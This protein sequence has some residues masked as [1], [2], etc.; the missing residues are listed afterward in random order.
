MADEC[1]LYFTEARPPLPQMLPG[2]VVDAA[3]ADA[4][5]PLIDRQDGP[6]RYFRHGTRSRS[7]IPAAPLPGDDPACASVAFTCDAADDVP[8]AVSCATRTVPQVL[9]VWQTPVRVMWSPVGPHALNKLL[10]REPVGARRRGGG[11]LLMSGL[12]HAHVDV[13]VEAL[14]YLF[15]GTARLAMSRMQE[16][17]VDEDAFLRCIAERAGTG[18]VVARRSAC[19]DGRAAGV[20]CSCGTL[21]RAGSAAEGPQFLVACWALDFGACL[22]S[23]RAR[24]EDG[25]ME[26]VRGCR[27]PGLL[28]AD[29]VAALD[30]AG[31]GTAGSNAA[32]QWCLPHC[33]PAQA[34]LAAWF[35]HTV[36]SS[37]PFDRNGAL[38][39]RL[40]RSVSERW[41]RNGVCLDE[42]T[43]SLLRR[44]DAAARDATSACVSVMTQVPDWTSGAVQHG[45]HVSA[46][47]VHC[48]DLVPLMAARVEAYCA[49]SARSHRRMP[50]ENADA[51]PLSQPQPQLQ[52][53]APPRQ[54][55]GF[56][57]EGDD[58]DEDVRAAK[59]QLAAHGITAPVFAAIEWMVASGV[60]RALKRRCVEGGQG[61]EAAVVAL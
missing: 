16:A 20:V 50:R 40:H 10:P 36:N 56:G 28:S 53:E 34:R 13:Q 27:F 4:A 51:L 33:S 18:V 15:G 17:A 29:A 52:P 21:C 39:S 61:P 57:R 2:V 30:A 41:V 32:G 45:A 14:R 26:V 31:S 9:L 55:F 3:A 42:D 11:D 25:A 60:R 46:A 8:L 23:M 37:V 59:Q 44:L 6:P 22:V 1:A 19:V 5:C 38:P 47:S 24:V 48:S 43:R 58:D 12:E 49:A 7:D 54:L 35:A